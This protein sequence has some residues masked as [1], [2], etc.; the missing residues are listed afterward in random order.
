[1][2]YSETVQEIQT[3][4]PDIQNQLQ[5]KNN[6]Y[7][8]IRVFTDHIKR[9][10]RQN[11]RNLIRASLNKM[12]AIYSQGDA[13]L[14]NAIENTFIYSL[15]NCTAFCTEEYRKL[16]FSCM[17]KDLQKSYTAQIYQHGI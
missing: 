6:P 17:S 15:D 1:M 7:T 12:S 13:A 14:K 10:I 9:M 3:I 2:N 16:I 4:V 5:E 11:D 8:A